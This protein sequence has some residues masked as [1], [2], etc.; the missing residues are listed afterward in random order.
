M[1][2]RLRPD[3]NA[4][5]EATYRH[6]HLS[7]RLNERRHR[8]RLDQ[9]SIGT[10]RSYCFFFQQVYLKNFRRSKSHLKSCYLFSRVLKNYIQCSNWHIALSSEGSFLR[11]MF[12]RN[13]FR[14]SQ[15]RST[16]L[17]PCPCWIRFCRLNFF[18]NFPNFFEVKIYIPAQ[19]I[20][21]F[22]SCS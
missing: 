18:Q 22:K 2:R 12:G 10:S 4:R 7:S 19:L 11:I 1:Q 14:I 17:S 16:F 21:S 9:N 5:L 13:L 6:S 3:S 20:E 8:G 15:S